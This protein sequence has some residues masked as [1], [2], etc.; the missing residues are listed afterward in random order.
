[1]TLPE[2]LIT[3]LVADGIAARV[4]LCV[5]GYTMWEWQR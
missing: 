2:L 4:L 5:V 1:M 3:L